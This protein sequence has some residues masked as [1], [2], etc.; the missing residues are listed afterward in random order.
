MIEHLRLEA[1]GNMKEL[2]GLSTDTKPMDCDPGTTFYEVDT[3]NAYI[4]SNSA[5][6]LM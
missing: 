2:Q 4:F 6:W 1:G 5:W 3:K